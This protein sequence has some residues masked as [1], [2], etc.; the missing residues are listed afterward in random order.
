MANPCQG[1]KIWDNYKKQCFCP[2][3]TVF[4]HGFCLPPEI[5]CDNGK[6][7]NPKTFKCECPEGKWFDGKKCVDITKC[8]GNQIYKPLNNKC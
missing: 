1:G 6:V 2:K 3:G 8:K 7:W 5:G 4:N